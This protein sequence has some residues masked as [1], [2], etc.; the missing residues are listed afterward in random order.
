MMADEGGEQKGCG[1]GGVVT[2]TER[3]KEVEE[4]DGKNCHERNGT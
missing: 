4:K 3:T 1:N 2:T